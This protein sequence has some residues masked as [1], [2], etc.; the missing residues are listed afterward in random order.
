MWKLG[1]C[2]RAI[3]FLG[4]FVSK[5]LV[6]CALWNKNCNEDHTYCCRQDLFHPLTYKT[7][8]LHSDNGFLPP[9]LGCSALC[10]VGRRLCLET[11]G[12][13]PWGGLIPTTAK[14]E[15]F[16]SYS[17]SYVKDSKASTVYKKV[18]W[19]VRFKEFKLS[20]KCV[21]FFTK[22]WHVGLPDRKINIR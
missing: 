15:V 13:G 2:G 16:F 20:K 4:I 14:S 11:A 22:R 3:F 8:C 12:G 7:Y 9:T 5:F 17:Y 1:L 18:V 10:V 19:R 21:A 6:L